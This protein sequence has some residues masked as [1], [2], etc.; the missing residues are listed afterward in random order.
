MSGTVFFGQIVTSKSFDELQSITDGYLVVNTEGTI[1]SIG[2]K[3]EF[4]TWND[5]TKRNLSVKQL[6]KDQFLIPGFIDCHLH[7]PQFP[8]LGL[9]LDK[10][11]LEWL[12]TY[13]F[14]L[15]ARYQDTT[16]A[17]TVY[18]VVVKQTLTRGTTTACYFGTIH[19]EGTKILAEEMIRQGQRGFVGKVNMNQLCPDN[20]IETTDDSVKDTEDFINDIQS[21]GS[22]LIQAAITPRFAIACSSELMQKLSNIAKKHNL[23]IQSHISENMKEIEFTKELYPD[24]VNYADVYRRN[25]VL[26]QKTIMAHC[27]HLEDA[28]LDIFRET[29][30]SVAHCPNS[31]TYL[32][33][34]IC[35]VK[36][37]REKSVK[38]GLGTDVSGG[39]KVGILDVIRHALEISQ[40]INFIRTQNIK[41]SGQLQEANKEP[42]VPYVPLKYVNALFLATLGGGEALSLQD[43]IGSFEVGKQ[44]DALLVDVS[45]VEV[46]MNDNG[47]TMDERLQQLIQRFVYSG[48]ERNIIEVFVNGRKVK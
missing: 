23:L 38:V 36:R 31:N 13:T 28:E 42:L 12:N 22:D 6:D 33:S 9:G 29:G 1:L 8:N 5:P 45:K 34:G 10:P 30:T 46:P 20:Y 25:G 15:E 3:D 39:N 32:S 18:N 24:A 35:D 48:D 16:F 44:F 7:A 17:R 27:V 19:R 41:G 21:L 4:D 47:R 37:I 40:M 26:T 11:L 2:N 14:P 43:K